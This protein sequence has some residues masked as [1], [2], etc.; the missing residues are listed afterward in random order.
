[1]QFKTW[2]GAFSLALLPLLMLSGCGTPADVSGMRITP[3][4]VLQMRS[5]IP[6]ALKGQM[7][8]APVTG[9]EP[10]GRFWGSRISNSMLEQS[11]DE[12]LRA[13]GLLTNVPG[14]GR[15]T[16]TAKLI[17]L[18]QPMVALTMKVSVIIEYSLIDRQLEDKVVYQHRLRTVHTVNFT[19]SMLDIN[20]RTRLASEGAVRRSVE[21]MVRELMEIEWS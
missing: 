13:L 11:I 12:S 3:A 7:V 6:P 17:E 4:D 14:G 8:L 2:L 10:T 15:Y 9:G 16:L 19:E 18:D 20:D 5:W 21:A 1:M